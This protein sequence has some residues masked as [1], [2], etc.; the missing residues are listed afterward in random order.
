MA[1]RSGRTQGSNALRHYSQVVTAVDSNGSIINS[2]SRAQ[3]RILLVSAFLPSHH[4]LPLTIL[5]SLSRFHKSHGAHS[6]YWL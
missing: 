5:P 3:V 2:S 6:K 4:T 1:A